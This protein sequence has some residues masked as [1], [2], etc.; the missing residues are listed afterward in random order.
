MSHW[1][2]LLCVARGDVP[3]HRAFVRSWVIRGAVPAR[4]ALVYY[5]V[6][7]S[8][9]RGDVPDHGAF[10]W[11]CTFPSTLFRSVDR[12]FCSIYRSSVVA[13]LAVHIG[14]WLMV[15]RSTILT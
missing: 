10:V 5:C 11:L 3:A 13:V 8:A 6:M 12:V 1:L 2:S 14:L 9:T 15:T 4:F 7:L